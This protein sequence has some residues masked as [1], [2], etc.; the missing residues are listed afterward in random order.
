[1]DFFMCFP[2]SGWFPRFA[3]A[4]VPCTEDAEVR[5]AETQQNTKCMHRKCDGAVAACHDPLTLSGG[6]LSGG[7]LTPYGGRFCLQA[8]RKSR[9]MAAQGG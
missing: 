4:S 8:G 5:R 9:S 3:R 2:R 1:M 7:K 6:E